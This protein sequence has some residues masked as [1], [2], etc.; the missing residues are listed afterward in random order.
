M[1]TKSLL[2]S[3]L[4]LSTIL[5]MAYQGD[6]FAPP[7]AKAMDVTVFEN[8]TGKIQSYTYI[9]KTRWAAQTF[10]PEISHIIKSVKVRI[11]KCYPIKPYVYVRICPV[12][13][14]YYEPLVDEVLAS[15]SHK[16]TSSSTYS[17]WLEIGL[18]EGSLLQAG[19]T[20]AIVIYTSDPGVNL[21]YWYRSSDLYYGGVYR[22]S[23][24]SGE[25]WSGSIQDMLFEEWGILPAQEAQK[26][27]YYENKAGPGAICNEPFQVGQ[28]FIPQK[29][30]VLSRLYLHGYVPFEYEAQ[31]TVKI[32]ATSGGL[33]SG[34][35]LATASVPYELLPLPGEEWWISIEIPQEPELQAGVM[36]AIVVSHTASEPF[37]YRWTT[38][39]DDVG[40]D[41]PLGTMVRSN[42]GGISWMTHELYDCCFQEWGYPLEQ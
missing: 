16:F 38:D 30:H 27:E 13:L 19:V 3:F 33:P 36:Y 41:Y 12:D 14:Q 35:P 18:G 21:F 28:T 2:L 34:A 7:K 6:I 11:K 42:D 29:R 26:I 32:M 17:G 15:G 9:S 8:N 10:T 40:A 37:G 4:I 20:Y 23:S 22:V 25:T 31:F 39:F 1:K 24:D 5:L